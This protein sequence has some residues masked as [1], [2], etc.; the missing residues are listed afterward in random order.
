[1]FGCS[2]QYPRRNPLGERFPSVVGQALDGTDISIPGDLVGKPVVLIIAFEKNAQFDADRWLLGLLQG[3]LTT[4]LYEVPTIPGTLP[5]LFASK[6]DEGMRGGIP[7]EDWATVVTVYGDADKIAQF[8]GNSRR[9]NTRVV[10]LDEQGV[11]R[12]FHD[13]G[14]SARLVPVV[15]DLTTDLARFAS[16]RIDEGL[17]SFEVPAYRALR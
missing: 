3:K 6:I 14:Y 4:P 2:A 11:V 1:M 13:R 12:Y 8:T 10:V 7:K 9:Q 16:L 5:G 17:D 15:V